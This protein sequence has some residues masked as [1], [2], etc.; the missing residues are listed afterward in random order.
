MFSRTRLQKPTTLLPHY[1]ES[2]PIRG[3]Q[4]TADNPPYAYT[5]NSFGH[6]EGDGTSG[7]W[8][9]WSWHLQNFHS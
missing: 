8:A 2:F 9:T 5:V 6:V 3:T 1:G 7:E 4:T